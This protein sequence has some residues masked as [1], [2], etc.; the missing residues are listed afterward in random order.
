MEII[1]ITEQDAGK[2]FK[3]LSTFI[4]CRVMLIQ[5]GSLKRGNITLE[6]TNDI[7]RVSVKH[8]PPINHSQEG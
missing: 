7:V 8:T 5:E 3:I 2:L 6:W 4:N 1:A